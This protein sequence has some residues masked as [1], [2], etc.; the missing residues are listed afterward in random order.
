MREEGK[1]AQPD[2][3]TFNSVMYGMASAGEWERLLDLLEGM[4]VDGVA[5]DVVSY[6]TAMGACNK[7][8]AFKRAPRVELGFVEGRLCGFPLLTVALCRRTV[9]QHR[10]TACFCSRVASRLPCLC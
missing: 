6:N 10:C 9:L 2:A 5:P 8:R 1:A 7:V 4:R 3:F